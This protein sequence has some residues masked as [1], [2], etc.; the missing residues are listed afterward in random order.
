MPSN[1]IMRSILTTFAA[2][3][4]APQPARPSRETANRSSRSSSR[5]GG[6]TTTTTRPN[7]QEKAPEL[8]ASAGTAN[9]EKVWK[10]KGM[11]KLQVVQDKSAPKTYGAQIGKHT[12]TVAWNRETRTWDVDFS[13]KAVG[14]FDGR[15]AAFDALN[16]AAKAA[17]AP[18]VRA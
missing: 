5:R 9:Q 1:T 15:V 17:R 16:V 13:G 2:A 18:Q 7:A 14:S 11:V 4:P 8:V 6:R 3:F 10:Y 12:Y